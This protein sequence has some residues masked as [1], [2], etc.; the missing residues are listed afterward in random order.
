MLVYGLCFNDVHTCISPPAVKHTKLSQFFEIVI[1]VVIKTPQPNKSSLY[2]Q[3]K[4]Y[5]VIFGVNAQSI[6][7]HHL[8][9]I[10]KIMKLIIKGD[11]SL[12]FNPAV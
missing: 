5:W 7:E 9:K 3:V 1:I 4:L 2:A 12:V 10:K 8:R 11:M 6:I